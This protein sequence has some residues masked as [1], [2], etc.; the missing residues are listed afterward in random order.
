VVESTALEMRRA[1]EGTQ[2]S[3]PCLSASLLLQKRVAYLDLAYMSGGIHRL[4]GI[5]SLTDRQIF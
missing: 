5:F 1:R 3:N 2:G 4:S